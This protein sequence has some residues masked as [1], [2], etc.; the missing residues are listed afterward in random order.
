MINDILPRSGGADLTTLGTLR[1]PP[2][3]LANFCHF[4]RGLYFSASSS[5]PSTSFKTGFMTS[6]PSTLFKTGFITGTC[7]H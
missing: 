1:M 2:R 7:A 6:E 5:A 4:S 3:V